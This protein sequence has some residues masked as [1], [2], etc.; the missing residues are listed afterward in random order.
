MTKGQHIRKAILLLI[1]YAIGLPIV[2]IGLAGEEISIFMLLVGLVFCGLP[3]GISFY[4]FGKRREDSESVAVYN[5]SEDG[6]YYRVGGWKKFLL[7]LLGLVVGIAA[8]PILAIYHLI[9]AIQ[10]ARS[11]K[12]AE[13]YAAFQAASAQLKERNS[14]DKSGT[15]NN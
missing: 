11:E 4:A 9:K 14:L 3:F 13:A 7:A 12:D 6:S 15:N 5:V 10:I 8:T 2:I 1:G